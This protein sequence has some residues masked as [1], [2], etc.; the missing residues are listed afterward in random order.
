MPDSRKQVSDA[1]LIEFL[2][3]ELEKVPQDCRNRFAKRIETMGGPAIAHQIAKAMRKNGWTIE[4]PVHD[5]TRSQ[6]AYNRTHLE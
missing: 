4:A 5:P 2:N 3:R 6:I 1:S